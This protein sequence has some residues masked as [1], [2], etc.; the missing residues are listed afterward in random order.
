MDTDSLIQQQSDRLLKE[1]KTNKMK[2]R[3]LRAVIPPA[4]KFDSG[5]FFMQKE[6]AIDR[7]QQKTQD[8]HESSQ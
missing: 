3:L 7:D 1:G 8:S 4:T 6:S 5:D 2:N